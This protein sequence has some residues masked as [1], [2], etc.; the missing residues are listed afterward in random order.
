M[1]EKKIF[2]MGKYRVE[3][4]VPDKTK[5]LKWSLGNNINVYDEND[6]FLWNI[7]ELLKSYSE[8]NGLQYYDDMYF[9]IR[10]LDNQN[11][12]CIGF[13]NHCEIDLK[14]KRIIKLVNNR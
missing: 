2:K 9:D 5:D 14:T 4:I 3:L 8:L 6:I 10:I 11:I 1:K 12:F 13:A 7:S